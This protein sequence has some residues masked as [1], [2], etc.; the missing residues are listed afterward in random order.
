MG[1]SAALVAISS[2]TVSDDLVAAAKRIAMHVVA[3]QPRFLQPDLVPQDLLNRERAI[4]HDQFVDSGKPEHILNKII[5]SKLNNFVSEHSLSSQVSLVDEED[6]KIPISTALQ[7]AHG[8]DTQLS[9]FAFF[10]VGED[11]S[12]ADGEKDEV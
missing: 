4:I 8:K 9:G 10:K 2:P 1:L 6:S 7:K 3:A 11:S 5:S 12:A